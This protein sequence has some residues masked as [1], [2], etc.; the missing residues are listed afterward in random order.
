MDLL[1]DTVLYCRHAK[2]T[3]LQTGTPSKNVAICSAFQLFQHAGKHGF[4]GGEGVLCNHQQTVN[5]HLREGDSTR[6]R[7]EDRYIYMDTIVCGYPLHS[8]LLETSTR[9][10][11][12]V[13][14]ERR[15]SVQT[16]TRREYCI[17]ENT[18]SIIGYPEC[19]ILVEYSLGLPNNDR[20]CHCN[21]Q[22][23]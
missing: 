20:L 12:H 8:L 18:L 5:A 3:K 21:T 4:S 15:Y 22:R 11:G 9:I 16:L 1:Q 6:T 7:E 14:S 2:K 17:S 19:N 13:V 10:A 23:S